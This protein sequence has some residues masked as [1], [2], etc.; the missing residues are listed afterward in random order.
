M[1]ECKQQHNQPYHGFFFFA[2]PQATT[3][4]RGESRQ[5][6]NTNCQAKSELK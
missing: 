4:G 6:T 2:Q 5:V 3:G 1:N